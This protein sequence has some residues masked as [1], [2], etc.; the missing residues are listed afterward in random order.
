MGSF[1]PRPKIAPGHH[2]RVV[3]D[4]SPCLAAEV[5]FHRYRVISLP[6]GFTTTLGRRKETITCRRVIR[7]LWVT[8]E[9]HAAGEFHKSR[10]PK[11]PAT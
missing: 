7:D 8:H 2:V 6:S 5:I 1:L 10:A 3:F 4:A 11:G 9:I